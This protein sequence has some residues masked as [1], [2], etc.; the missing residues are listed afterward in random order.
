MDFKIL[1]CGQ[2]GGL[3]GGGVQEPLR[4]LAEIIEDAV[5]SGQELHILVTDL[6]KAFDSVEYWSQAMSWKALGVPEEMIELL[7][8]L[9]RGSEEGTGATTTVGL[10]Q[11]HETAP[12]RHGRGLRQGSVGGPLKWC[13]FVHF[14]IKWI[15]KKMRG[16]G[17]TMS[18]ANKNISVPEARGVMDH[19]QRKERRE[20]RE[21]EVTGQKFIDDATWTTGSGEAA[22]EMVKMHEIFCEFHKVMLEPKKSKRYAINEKADSKKIYWSGGLEIGNSADEAIK[23]LGVMFDMD[24]SWKSETKRLQGKLEE[25][26]DTLA[27]AKA[28]LPMLTYGINGK[29]IPTLTYSLQVAP[30]PEKVIKKWDGV[31]R[32]TVRRASS[33][34]QGLPLPM[35]YLK[36][37][38]WGLGLRSLRDIARELRI[39]GMIIALNSET[40]SRYEATPTI[41]G[42]VARAG[43]DR[44]SRTT[45]TG[46]CR[47]NPTNPSEI[48]KSIQGAAKEAAKNLGL[49]FIVTKPKERVAGMKAV[50]WR[51]AASC[52]TSGPLE[53]YTDGS[54]VDEGSRSGWG[55]VAWPKGTKILKPIR[56]AKANLLG[57]PDNFAAESTALLSVL[58]AHSLDTPLDIYID[59]AAVVSRWDIDTLDKPK[60]RMDTP[61]RTLWTRIQSLASWRTAPTKVIW[62]TSHVEEKAKAK[63]KGKKVEEGEKGTEKR[64]RRCAC[65]EEKGKCDPRHRHHVG[66]ELADEAAKEGTD[67]MGVGEECIDP[68]VGEEKYQL[69][70]EGNPVQGAITPFIKKWV[71]EKLIKDLKGSAKRTIKE[72][73]VRLDLSDETCRK[74]AGKGNRSSRGHKVR[75]MAEQLPNYKRDMYMREKKEEYESEAEGIKAEGGCPHCS[76]EGEIIRE[77]QAHTFTECNIPGIREIKEA[78]KRKIIKTWR[79][80]GKEECGT[81]EGE[82]EM[83]DPTEGGP[84]GWEKWWGWIGLYPKQYTKGE[85]KWIRQAG[86]KAAKI[87]EEAGVDIWKARN[88]WVVAWEK[89]KG[90]RFDKRKRGSVQGQS[91][92]RPPEVSE[93]K[94]EAAKRAKERA[95]M[96][97]MHRRN[98]DEKLEY[99]TVMSTLPP[100]SGLRTVPARRDK[101]KEGE[102]RKKVRITRTITREEDAELQEKFREENQTCG[103][104]GCESQLPPTEIADNC[105]NKEPRC[106]RHK[107]IQCKGLATTCACRK[108]EVKRVKDPK[109]KRRKVSGAIPTPSGSEMSE[110]SEEE[111]ESEE[112][113]GTTEMGE[114]EQREVSEKLWGTEV[115]DTI[116]VEGPGGSTRGWVTQ[117]QWTGEAADAYREPDSIW[118]TVAASG[119]RRKVN[120]R[121]KW[122]VQN[123]TPVKRNTSAASRNSY[124]ALQEDDEAEE[125]ENSGAAVD[126]PEKAHG[127]E[128]RIRGQDE[129]LPGRRDQQDGVD[130]EEARCVAGGPGREGDNEGY[131]S[132]GGRDERREARRRVGRG[133]GGTEDHREG[134]EVGERE[135]RGEDHRCDAGTDETEPTS[136]IEWEGSGGGGG[137]A[138]GRGGDR[139]GGQSEGSRRGNTNRVEE[140]GTGVGREEGLDNNSCYEGE[141]GNRGGGQ[142]R[143]DCDRIRVGMGG[144]NRRT[145]ERVGEGRHHRPA[146]T[147]YCGPRAKGRARP[148]DELSDGGRK[149]HT[150]SGS[151]QQ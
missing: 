69:N 56:R 20:L 124:A 103:F 9:D 14:W 114:E 89:E 68:Y 130:H 141:G 78:A 92:E 66:N 70:K 148:I 149:R 94:E 150:V 74:S 55:W 132:E 104:R 72:V 76:R 45:T 106:A 2:Y 61:A 109:T 134:Q 33:M 128:V 117:M 79:E 22:Q 151:G 10:A 77:T 57:Q 18:A 127:E 110:E 140:G 52:K 3:A 119:K 145:E 97:E 1:D 81:A 93:K 36:E 53:V 23:Y 7:V 121:Q 107:H 116:T 19:H 138:R 12:F 38:D 17:Y 112:G 71:Y 32:K 111:G 136:R 48:K 8:N 46:P 21:A 98:M 49:T 47:G 75:A 125:G 143:G 31:I 95:E 11:G 108:E 67:E 102:R 62:V 59:N 25:L 88:E 60:E 82:W 105:A 84:Q 51:E 5:A 58:R 6:S 131:Q 54:T 122:V 44:H 27:T 96:E 24:A 73:G 64:G 139:S 37:E 120:A 101:K 99:D 28:S 147:E 100:D 86:R 15:K 35:Y 80:I 87:L 115:G 39:K 118:I 137:Q 4:I 126:S 43:W 40:Y 30:I 142:E 26:T 83:R 63:Q 34:P 85:K 146:E 41:L 13:V 129:G 123:R 91:P 135:I 42:K 29:I 144:G 16:K 65:G 113:A 90:I 50:D 133:R